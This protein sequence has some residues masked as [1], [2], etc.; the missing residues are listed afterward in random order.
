[1]MEKLERAFAN[2]EWCNACP[3]C[4]I[5]NL[6]IICSNHSLILLDTTWSPLFGQR[7]FRFEWIWTS[8]PDFFGIIQEAWN[9]KYQG[10]RA[11]KLVQRIKKVKEK[12]KGWN[13]TV[14]GQV[15]REI[16][17]KKEKLQQ[18]QANIKSLQDV[19]KEMDVSS[20]LETLLDREKLCG[21]KKLRVLGLS[22]EIETQIFS[23]HCK[24]Q[25]NPKQNH[26]NQS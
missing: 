5:Q 13:H 14:F 23:N 24:K 2:W 21:L 17:K 20:Q 12:L 18:I 1:M 4:L 8:H 25:K 7:P 9:T 11:F 22:R 19:Q 15:Q 16:A 3:H 6:P 26:P 10:S